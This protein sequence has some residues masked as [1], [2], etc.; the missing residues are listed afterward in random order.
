MK[1]PKPINYNA[2][3]NFSLSLKEVIDLAN[4]IAESDISQVD[5]MKVRDRKIRKMFRKT[6][7]QRHKLWLKIIHL[8][9]KEINTQ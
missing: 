7:E 1:Q 4:I 8:S 6:Y 2:M 3:I 5:F 9:N